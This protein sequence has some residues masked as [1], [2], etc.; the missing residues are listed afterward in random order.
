MLKVYNN[1]LI[2]LMLFF[3]SLVQA[4]QIVEKPAKPAELPISLKAV[5]KTI[6]FSQTSVFYNQMMEKRSLE[7]FENR[8]I[9]VHFWASWFMDCH[10]E[11]I[12]LNKL[13][14]D[15]R[16]KSLLIISISEDFKGADAIDQYFIK[17]KIDYLDIYLDKKNKIYHSLDLKHLPISYL[18]DYDGRVIAESTPG[19]AVD[20]NDE[21]IRKFLE[22]KVT[23]YQLLPPEFKRLRD[24]YEVQPQADKQK[25]IETTKSK[26]FVN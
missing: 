21:D 3:S 12:A 10:N 7:N 25:K 22:E 2:I 16:K 1:Y 9:I 4:D 17:H 11:L 6:A 20:W 15:F 5:H 19:V 8:F 13:Q 18:I 14:K 23:Q 26:I 24:P